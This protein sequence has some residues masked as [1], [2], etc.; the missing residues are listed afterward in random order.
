M[1]MHQPA[2]EPLLISFS[3]RKT[4]LDQATL[5]SVRSL[6]GLDWFTFFLGDIQSGLGPFPSVY[7]VTQKWTQTDIGLVLALGGLVS[8]LGQIPG[9]AL[10]DSIK[11]ERLAAAA[12][13]AGIGISAFLIS[14]WPVFAPRTLARVF[15]APP[16][17]VLC[18]DRG[19]IPPRLR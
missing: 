5:P 18:P 4:R 13:V 8:L 16:G 11:S 17:C 3:P 6:R 7:L 12:A 15:P 19:G 10:V 9:G 2:T 1:R 14:G